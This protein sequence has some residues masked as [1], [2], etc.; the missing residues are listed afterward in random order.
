MNTIEWFLEYIAI[1]RK[2]SNR[3]VEAYR[4]DL[5]GFCASVGWEPE[6]FDPSHVDESDIKAWMIAMLDEG[7]SPRS[8]KRYLSSLRSFYKFMLRVG[9]VD[10]DITRKIVSPKEDKPLPVFFRESEMQEAIAYETQADDFESVRNC[11]IIEMLYQ[12]GMR[13][14][15]MLGLTDSDIDLVQGQIRIFGKRKK[16]RIVPVL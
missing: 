8:I 2:Y 14:A 4:D 1:E 6:D 10:K 15:E 16:E 11:L 7:K 5:R 9:I 3:T 12:T 13:Q